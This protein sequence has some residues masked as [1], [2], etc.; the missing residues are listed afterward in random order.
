MLALLG[1]V[2]VLLMVY[3]LFFFGPFGIYSVGMALF[4]VGAR[5]SLALLEDKPRWSRTGRRRRM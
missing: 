1:R 2:A 4:L 5:W 3:G